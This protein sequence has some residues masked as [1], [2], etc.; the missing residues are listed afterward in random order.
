MLFFRRFIDSDD[1]SD[2]GRSLDVLISRVFGSQGMN[3]IPDRNAHGIHFFDK[4]YIFCYFIGFSICA[5]SP[6]VRTATRCENPT[7]VFS[8]SACLPPDDFPSSA[9]PKSNFPF[10][11]ETHFAKPIGH[12][13]ISSFAACRGQVTAL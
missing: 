12:F 10:I 4:F 1:K 5:E 2:E 11:L 8:L 7:R 13:H 9:L 3:T 6:R